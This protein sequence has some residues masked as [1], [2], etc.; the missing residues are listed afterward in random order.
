MSGRFVDLHT[1]TNA[2]DGTQSP[3]ENVQLAYRAGL[4]GVAI[5]DHDT[6][7]GI[8][9]ARRAGDQL[10]ILVVPGVEI[11]TVA[12]GQDIHVLGYY[13]DERCPVFLDRL[14]KLRQIR[15]RR[16]EWMLEKLRELGLDVSLEE[17]IANASK[18]R[19]KDETI[20]RPH[21]AELLVSKGYVQSM[22]EAFDKY[23]GTGGAAYVNP[24]RIGPK[25]AIDWIHEAGGAAVLAHPG[26]YRNDE[27]V[28]EIIRY[29]LDGI[30]ACHSD[31]SPA[32]EE[33]YRELAARYHLAVTAGSDFHGERHGQVFHGPI[34]NRKAE[35]SVLESLQKRRGD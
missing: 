25:E 35:W 4:S 5:T 13:M 14:E 6:V 34:G 2:S 1:H 29:G 19:G 24:P 8:E 11:S 3:A 20:G 15:D 9:E 31:H 30:E 12:G 10:G 28:E 23:L 22:E 16:N 18:D 7:A 27:L 32:E 33:K 26:I 17:V 21:I